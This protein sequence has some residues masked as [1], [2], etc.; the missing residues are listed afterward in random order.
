MR[1]QTAQRRRQAQ[2]EQ[3]LGYRREYEQRWSAAVLPRRPDRAG[4][5]LPGLH[6]AADPG[7]R[8]AGRHCA[9]TPRRSS[10]A[11]R[12]RCASREI[13]VASVK[14]LIERRIRKASAPAERARAEAERRVRRARGVAGRGYRPRPAPGLS[15]EPAMLIR[16]AASPLAPPPG[17]AAPVAEPAPHPFAALLRQNQA[18]AKPPAPPTPPRSPAPPPSLGTHAA[19]PNARAVAPP[20]RRRLRRH[21]RQPA[22][23]GAG[24]RALGRDRAGGFAH[25][26]PGEDR[27]AAATAGEGR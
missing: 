12:R 24:P 23:E 20:P 27:G 14:K 5:L 18:A 10:N 2:A 16:N 19:P 8:A 17:A 21:R 9:R 25:T 11:R 15:A 13:Q 7:G 6:G 22:G 3:L 1:A 26:E 4:A